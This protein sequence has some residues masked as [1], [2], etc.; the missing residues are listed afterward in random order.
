MLNYSI[1][2]RARGIAR[3]V[4]T[5][6]LDQEKLLENSDCKPP[7]VL[8][9]NTNTNIIRKVGDLLDQ[10]KEPQLPLCLSRCFR[11][12]LQESMPVNGEFAP[13]QGLQTGRIVLD[14][15]ALRILSRLQSITE[16]T[17]IRQIE[18]LNRTQNSSSL[19][20]NGH[21]APPLAH[22]PLTVL[23]KQT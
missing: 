11:L 1:I 10:V 19:Q 2:Q 5:I 3:S 12:S 16:Q 18:S 9:Y 8:Y 14:L 15:S 23:K 13:A 22:S 20:P 21:Q 4:A 17:I 6:A 7:Y